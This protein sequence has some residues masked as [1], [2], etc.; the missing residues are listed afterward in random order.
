MLPLAPNDYGAGVIY[1]FG[2]MEEAQSATIR[3]MRG[4]DIIDY[5]DMLINLTKADRNERLTLYAIQDAGEISIVSSGTE[6]DEADALVQNDNFPEDTESCTGV[7]GG[8]CSARQSGG[9]TTVPPGLCAPKLSGFLALVAALL[10]CSAVLSF[11]F[12]K[13]RR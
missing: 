1:E 12:S 3:I 13:K 2:T 11:L 9:F 5:P 6:P 4:D 7:W 10:L 8:R